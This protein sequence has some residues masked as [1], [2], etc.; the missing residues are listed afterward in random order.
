MTTREAYLANANQEV[1]MSDCLSEEKKVLSPILIASNRGPI[2]LHKNIAGEIEFQR[3]AGGLVTALTGITHQVEATWV[4]CA[5]TPEDS[6]WR[7]GKV[8]LV[9]NG[10]DVH[11]KFLSPN[12]HAYDGY[13]NSIA[14]PLLWFLQHS[15]WDVPHDPIINKETWNAW[16]EGYLE[17]NRLF[18]NHIAEICT[19]DK[20]PGLVMLQ[21]YHLYMV[22]RYLRQQLRPSQRPIISHFVHIPW[23]GPEYWGILPPTMR[24]AIFDSL[25]AVDVLGFQTHNDALNFIRTCQTYLP[26]ASVSFKYDRIWYRNH[27]THVRDFPISID[28]QALKDLAQKPEVADYETEIK[29]MVGDRKLILRIEIGRAH[30]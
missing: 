1:S 26:R 11:I 27:A 28:V 10:V 3:G 8:P 25:C 2:T 30:V 17:V 15:M 22:A 7:E 6:H 29:N 23:P 5:N 16:D 18:A 9:D 4:S 21:D 12:P 13:Y 19:T 20:K 14:N 24:Q